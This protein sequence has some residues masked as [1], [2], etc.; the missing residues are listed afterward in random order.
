MSFGMFVSSTKKHVSRNV[1]NALKKAP[2]F[3]S[4]T[5]FPKWFQARVFHKGHVFHFF[6]GDGV[7]YC[8][9]L[10]LLG[11]MVS[12][13]G[14]GHVG[15]FYVAKVVLGQVPG[16]PSEVQADSSLVYPPS[17]VMARWLCFERLLS[18]VI[19]FGTV[20]AWERLRLD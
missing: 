3:V 11:P 15:I 10:V 9:C 12:S 13:Q 7:N 14:D 2:D 6:S 18:F 16:R 19:S 1:A 17:E 20:G 4:K 5:S 8:I